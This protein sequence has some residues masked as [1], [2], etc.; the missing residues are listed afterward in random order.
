M[1]LFLYSFALQALLLAVTP[2]SGHAGE[3]AA[4]KAGEALF[5]NACAS[6]HGPVAQGMEPIK[7]PPIAGQPGWY[8]LRQL[9]N[10]REGRR[11]T[12]AAEPQAMIMAAMVK[13]LSP[14]QLQS[15][16]NYLQSLPLVV[17]TAPKN[18][19]L[20]MGKTLFEERCMECHRY[21]GSGEMTFGSPPL[22]GLPDWYLIAQLRKFKTGERGAT[23]ADP[24]G[25]KMVFSSQFIESEEA[26]CSVV[27]YIV[28]LNA[29]SKPPLLDDLFQAPQSKSAPASPKPGK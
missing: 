13:A 16:A 29:P 18:A 17:P 22:V 19:N 5:R 28:T 25:A 1:R 7:V 24:Y 23:P 4:K 14:G 27:S 21:N 2:G 8:V 11:G 15:V 9:D 20:A 10:F 6:C 26:L 3:D 12:N